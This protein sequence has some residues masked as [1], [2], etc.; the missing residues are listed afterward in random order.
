M[1]IAVQAA[2]IRDIEEID[3]F[4]ITVNDKN[5]V[6]IRKKLEFEKFKIICIFKQ[7]KDDNEIKSVWRP[8]NKKIQDKLN[9]LIKTKKIINNSID[10]IREVFY[11]NK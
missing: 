4:M 6:K 9:E 7:M 10:K 8:K 3:K 5:Y 2:L 11:K 1:E